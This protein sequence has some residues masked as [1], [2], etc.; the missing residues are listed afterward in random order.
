MFCCNWLKKPGQTHDILRRLV[1]A[2]AFKLLHQLSPLQF[3]VLIDHVSCK[4][5]T[6]SNPLLDHHREVSQVEMP[7]YEPCCV[8]QQHT[9]PPQKDLPLVKESQ[10]RPRTVNIASDDEESLQA[11]STS[12]ETESSSNPLTRT[13]WPLY[14][15]H[16]LVASRNKPAFHQ[17]SR[18][19]KTIKRK[20][21]D[22]ALTHMRGLPW[23]SDFD[24][25][26]LSCLEIFFGVV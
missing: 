9:E 16:V 8:L 25:V 6:P 14:M 13:V 20:L 15:I 5:G 2:R 3:V 18:P 4:Q 21:L 11:E 12:G 17:Q 19:G 26:A 1:F 23:Q 7:V 24:S 10:E 22:L